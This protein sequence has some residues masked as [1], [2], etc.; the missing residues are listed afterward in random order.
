MSAV[1]DLLAKWQRR[2]ATGR[3]EEIDEPLGRYEL[4]VLKVVE[5]RLRTAIETDRIT[6]ERVWR[7]AFAAGMQHGV[8]FNEW[9]Q[10]AT[11]RALYGI[12]DPVPRPSKCP[13]Y[14]ETN[15]SNNG[16]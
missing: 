4:E 12:D 1:E 9:E 14:E 10:R 3:V 6:L 8:D 13:Y 7:E 11:A 16:E 2:L 5:H 15:N